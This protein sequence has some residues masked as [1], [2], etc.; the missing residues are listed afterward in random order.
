MRSL[1]RTTA[2]ALAASLLAGLCACAGAGTPSG[3]A[4]PDATTPAESAPR[5][6]ADLDLETLLGQV[7]ESFGQMLLRKIDEFLSEQERLGRRLDN[8]NSKFPDHPVWSNLPADD[9]RT[10][11]ECALAVRR[12]VKAAPSDNKP[13][14]AVKRSFLV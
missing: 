12:T 11:L 9:V 3:S 5:A 2:L 1:F 4:S 6:G 13:V 7:D 14:P 8:R 10:F